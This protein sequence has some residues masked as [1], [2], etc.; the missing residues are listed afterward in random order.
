MR[1]LHFSLPSDPRPRLGLLD[2]R[3]VI[4]VAQV[5]GAAGLAAP[6]DL[7][8]AL[9]QG[10]AALAPVHEAAHHFYDPQTLVLGPAVLA[11][12]KI[13]CIGLNYR[14]H[15]AETRQAPPAFPILFS[16][17]NNALAGHRQPIAL[18]AEAQQCDYEAELAVVIGRAAHAVDEASALD[19]VFGYCCAND[20]SARDWQFRTGQWLLGKTPDHF[21]PLGPHL[22]TADEIPDP[23]ALTLSCRVN[24]ERRQHANTADMIFP[25]ARLIAYISHHLTLQ[26]GDVIVTGTP[27]G[28]ALG[29]AQPRW[30][31]PGDVIAVEISGLGRL[32]NHIV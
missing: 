3:G 32:E 25:V 2:P 7:A 27:E 6:T 16:K 9:A 19:Y 22:V 30:L 15:A 31:Q 28:V 17:F 8:G 14:N 4:D 21:L 29:M 1:L 13:I 20:L 11:P 23:Q 24:G 10:A 18:P 26:P 5:V 12:E